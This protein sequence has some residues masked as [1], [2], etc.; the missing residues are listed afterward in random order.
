[1][2][3]CDPRDGILTCNDN[4]PGCD[5]LTSTTPAVNLTANVRKKVA[6]VGSIDD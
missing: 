5:E 6:V 2:N 1:M 4:G 3:T